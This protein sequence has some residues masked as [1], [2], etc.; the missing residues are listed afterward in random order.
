[1]TGQVEVRGAD[2]LAATLRKAAGRIGDCTAPNTAAAAMLARQAASSAP[3]RTGRLAGSI[4]TRA[5]AT[6]A[7][8][9]VAAPYGR[10]VEYGTRYM[11]AQPYLYPASGQVDWQRPYAD[12]VSAAMAGVK[13]A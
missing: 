5:D 3:R 11:R 9:D 6:G 12:H 4:R 8:V 2:V 13:G 10:F 1:M 7:S